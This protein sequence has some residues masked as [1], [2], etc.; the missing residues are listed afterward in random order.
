MNTSA[1]LTLKYLTAGLMIDT[2]RQIYK[3]LYYR[4]Q[5]DHLH[6]REGVRRNKGGVLE[7]SEWVQEGLHRDAEV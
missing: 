5:L 1:E 6:T 4:V 3:C 2:A 7:K